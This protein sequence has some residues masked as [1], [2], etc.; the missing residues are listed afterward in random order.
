MRQRLW[1]SAFSLLLFQNGAYACPWDSE[2]YWAEWGSLPCVMTVLVGAFPEHTKEYYEARISAADEAL[3]FAPYWLEGLD[4]KGVALLKLGRLK[5][6]EAVFVQRQEADPEGYATHANLGTLYTFTG[7]FEKALFH[8]DKSMKIE[9]EAH[10]GREKYHRQL[11]VYLAETKK[12]PKVRLTQNF[13]GVTIT[14]EQRYR[15][16]KAK[17]EA[18]GLSED[19]FDA[20]A[21]MIAVYGAKDMPDIYLAFGDALALRGEVKLAWTAYQ[22]AA[23]LKHPRKKELLAWQKQFWEMLFGKSEFQMK[24]YYTGIDEIY[25]DERASGKRTAKSYADWER[26]Q[27]KEGLPVYTSSGLD[28]IYAKQREVSKRCKSP[29][30]ILAQPAEAQ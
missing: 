8:I 17:F 6:A 7:D 11:V 10:F 5:E 3:R 26:K 13:L 21:S 22:R 29:G 19:V 20:M 25:Q 18:A 2:T 30:V 15:G 28:R 24:E 14:N 12:D 23:E 9:P 27:I 16:S 1:I 4:M